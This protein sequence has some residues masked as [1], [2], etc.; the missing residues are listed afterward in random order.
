METGDY[1]Y[2]YKNP[3]TLD[4]VEKNLLDFVKATGIS[5][6]VFKPFIIGVLQDVAD[7][8]ENALEEF[9]ERLYRRFN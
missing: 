1:V 7:F 9:I 5:N 3:A 4:S 8:D 2:D 6:S